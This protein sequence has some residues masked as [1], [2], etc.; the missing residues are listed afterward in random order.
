LSPVFVVQARDPGQEELGAAVREAFIE[1]QAY[2][3]RRRPGQS[4]YPSLHL[5]TP[6]GSV[7]VPVWVP[8]LILLALFVALPLLLV[9]WLLL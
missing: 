7:L 5:R 3:G 1:E 8:T 9:V 6:F 2:R 4:A